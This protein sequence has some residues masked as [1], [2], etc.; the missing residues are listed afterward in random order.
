M[1]VNNQYNHWI[2]SVQAG[3]SV[4]TS[5]KWTK[6]R[7]NIS[8]SAGKTPKKYASFSTTRFW[9]HLKVPFNK[10]YYNL[11]PGLTT[12]ELI[13]NAPGLSTETATW[14]RDW[15]SVNGSCV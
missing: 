2:L 3:L 5:P 15:K 4:L 10:I 9:G 1:A 6:T 12:L 14:R 7:A 13:R 8:K 11:S